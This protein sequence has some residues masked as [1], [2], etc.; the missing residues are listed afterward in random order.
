MCEA[1]KES[2]DCVVRES[3]VSYGL[4]NVCVSSVCLHVVRG[5][6]RIGPNREAASALPEERERERRVLLRRHFSFNN[7][8]KVWIHI[9]K[10][11][12]RLLFGTGLG[13]WFFVDSPFYYNDASRS[14]A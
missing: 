2:G 12:F 8:S 9:T 5:S 11:A 7:L 13:V 6:G 1:K 3:F 4:S 14:N 10:S